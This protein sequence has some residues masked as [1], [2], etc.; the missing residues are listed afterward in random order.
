[1]KNGADVNRVGTLG[2]SLDEALRF[3]KL[4]LEGSASCSHRMA[5][6]GVLTFPSGERRFAAGTV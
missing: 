6:E 3:H 2:G 5:A 4:D 1:M